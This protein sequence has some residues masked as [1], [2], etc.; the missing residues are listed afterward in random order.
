MIPSLVL[1]AGGAV[2]VAQMVEIVA[3]RQARLDRIT[4]EA[5]CSLYL[6]PLDARY[7]EPNRW[8]GPFDPGDGAIRQLRVVRPDV[9]EIDL[10]ADRGEIAR[11]Y[12]SPHSVVQK[13]AQTGSGGEAF[14]FVHEDAVTSSCF[15]MMPMLQ[16]VDAQVHG[17]FVRGLTLESL[18]TDY[19]VNV[20]GA[21]D[22]ATTYAVDVVPT[23]VSGWIEHYDFDL[24]SRGTP[25]R[26]HL[27]KER[28]S[29]A[30]FS[31]D[32]EMITLATQELGGAELAREAVVMMKD[33]AATHQGIYR[34]SVC[35][36]SELPSLGAA[37]IQITPATRNAIVTY[38]R[39][40]LVE[41][42]YHY[43]SGGVL[44]ASASNRQ[45]VTRTFLLPLC[46]SASVVGCVGAGVLSRRRRRARPAA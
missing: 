14:Y 18:L 38:R 17:S 10:A 26:F 5:E 34:I 41:E 42:T 27:F 44:V 30:P 7:D 39:P 45:P 35:D 21:S 15:T 6:A 33:S 8:D 29:G 11:S 24:N 36:A 37:D 22:E 4:I 40:D 28:T 2:P 13:I 23:E 20:I 1:L 16:L 19:P 32:R 25:L 12:F 46:V 9:L 31:F 3:D 43:D